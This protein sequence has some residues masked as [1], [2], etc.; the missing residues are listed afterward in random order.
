MYISFK[1]MFIPQR[2]HPCSGARDVPIYFYSTSSAFPGARITQ[3]ATL[4]AAGVLSKWRLK[5]SREARLELRRGGTSA[6]GQG[7]PSLYEQHIP[8][9]Y[10]NFLRQT[11]NPNHLL[12]FV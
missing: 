12:Q 9:Y 3:K 1:E 8:V 5:S 4:G 10:F 2:Q 11:Q 7:R 6:Q